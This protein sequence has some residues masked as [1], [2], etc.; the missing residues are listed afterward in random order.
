MTEAISATHERVRQV[1]QIVCEP[2]D[3]GALGIRSLLGGRLR[4][5]APVVVPTEIG[6]NP[7]DVLRP[8]ARVF[9]GPTD[10]FTCRGEVPRVPDVQLRPTRN[11]ISPIA[12]SCAANDVSVTS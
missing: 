3:F 11:H 8:A 6:D 10:L 12:D 5:A 4:G 7:I 1:L 2:A 9:G